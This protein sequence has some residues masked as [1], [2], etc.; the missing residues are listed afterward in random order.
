MGES[1][2]ERGCNSREYVGGVCDCDLAQEA[3]ADAIANAYARGRAEGLED[4]AKMLEEESRLDRRDA[5]KF[6]GT[7]PQL[8]DNLRARAST[9][10]SYAARIRAMVKR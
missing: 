7:S 8:A 3:E 1:K 4:A 6:D 10:R 2:H 5:S 9:A